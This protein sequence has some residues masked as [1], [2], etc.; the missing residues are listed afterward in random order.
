MQVNEPTDEQEGHERGGDQDDREP[1]AVDPRVRG[2]E[3]QPAA[4]GGGHGR[5]DGDEPEQGDPE[6]ARHVRGR[7]GSGEPEPCDGD[8]REEQEGDGGESPP[9]RARIAAVRRAPDD[10][11]PPTRGSGAVC[12]SP[13]SGYCRGG[14]GG[15]PAAADGSGHAVHSGGGAPCGPPAMCG[16][17]MPLRPS[18]WGSSRLPSGADCAPLRHARIGRLR[19]GRLRIVE[20]M[21]ALA[22]QQRVSLFVN[23]KPLSTLE[24]DKASKRYDVTVPAALL[25]PGDNRVRLTFK[26]AADVAGGKRAAAAVTSLA[27]GPAALGAPTDTGAPLAA[28]EVD[29]RRRAPACAGA[30]RRRLADF[31]STSSCRRARTW[32]SGTA[33]RARAARCWRRSPSTASP[34]ARCTRATS[35]RPGRMRSSISA[36]R[37]AR[38]RAST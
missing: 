6:V 12:G 14:P 20:F 19:S 1:R 10:W 16:L 18:Q 17:P 24:V 32:R 29:S 34:R 35:A 3:Q 37:A 23:E 13:L 8:E 15:G 28:R 36:P 31:V 38:R 30:G 26:S 33:P 21:R 27:L 11:P 2:C 22:P 9:T 25:H 4:D 5:A 7:L